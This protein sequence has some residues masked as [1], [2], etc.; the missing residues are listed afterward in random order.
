MI[1]KLRD[2]EYIM[3]RYKGNPLITTDDFPV[4]AQAVFNCGQTMFEGK[5]VLLIAATYKKPINGKLTGIHVAMSDDG[6]NF[7]INKEA[8]YD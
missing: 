4:P 6:I 8:H 5:T 2:K 7:K 1:T 3:H